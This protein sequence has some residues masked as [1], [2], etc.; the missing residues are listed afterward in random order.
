MAQKFNIVAQLQLQGPGNVR[1]VVSRLQRQLGGLNANVNLNVSKSGLQALQN[2]QKSLNNI[3]AQVAK[4]NKTLSQLNS[5]TSKTSS[6]VNKTSSSLKEAGTSAQNFGHQI[7]LATKRFAAFSI[8]GGVLISFTSALKTGVSEAINFE[9]QMVKV[10]QVTGKT[11]QSL[12][13]L[14]K[15]I[16]RLA[17]GMGV[18]SSELIDV[19]RTLAQTGLAAKD[20]T[21]ALKTLAQSSLAPTF[22]DMANTAEGAIAIMRQ[23]GVTA[24]QLGGKLGSINALAGQFAVESQDLIFAIRRAGG[25]FQAAGGNLEE[26]LALFTSVRATTRES[27]ETIATGF[28]TIFTRIQRPKTIEFLRQAGVELQN[29]QGNFVGPFEAIKRLNKALSTLET[30]DPRFQQIIEELGGFRQVSK[31]IPLIQQFGTAQRALNVAIAGQGSLAKDAVTAQQSLAVQAV[32]VREQFLALFREIAGTTAFQAFAKTALSIASAMIKVGDAIKPVLPLI[33]GLAAFKT[34]QLGSQFVSG[35]AGGLGGGGARGAGRGAAGQLTGQAQ[36]ASAA[37]QVQALTTNTTAITKLTAAVNS[38]IPPINRLSSSNQKIISSGAMGGRSG[39]RRFA[40]GGIVPGT[41]TG[42]TVPAMLEPGE[43]VIRKSSVEKYGA[44]NLQR[45]NRGGKKRRGISKSKRAYAFDFDDTLA[46]SDAVVREGAED[47]YVDFRGKRGESFVKSATATKIASMA[48]TRASRGHDIFV[49][50]ARPGDSSTRRGISGFMS[51][52]G[53]TAKDIIGVGGSP[54]PGDTSQKKAQVLN[55]LKKQYGNIT[56]LDDDDANVLA[57]SKIPG[58]KSI[59]ARK[60]M[61]GKISSGRGLPDGHALLYGQTRKS[62]PLTVAQKRANDRAAMKRGKKKAD[63]DELPLRGFPGGLPINMTPRTHIGGIHLRDGAKTKGGA[64]TAI[65]YPGIKSFDITNPAFIDYWKRSTAKKHKL[66]SRQR[67]ATRLQGSMNKQTFMSYAPSPG[68]LKEVMGTQIDRAAAKGA[69]SGVGRAVS[70]LKKNATFKKA[71]VSVDDNNIAAAKA[72][73][74]SDPNVISSV[75]GFIY[76][77]VLTALTGTAMG[78][79]KA[80]FDIPE[81]T[82]NQRSAWGKLFGPGA[83]KLKT[84]EV[85]RSLQEMKAGLKGTKVTREFNNQKRTKWRD[86]ANVNKDSIQNRLK[87]ARRASGGGISGSDTVPAL[88]TPGEFVVN[89]KSA[90]RIGYGALDKI[91]KGQAQGFA[92]GGIVKKFRRGGRASG[93]DSGRGFEKL[94]AAA[95]VLPNILEQLAA[96]VGTTN[97]TFSN[98]VSGLTGFLGTLLTV[99]I[100]FES[101]G[102]QKLL[103]GLPGAAGGKRF[104]RA[105]FGRTFSA[106]S[107]R[108]VNTLGMGKVRGNVKAFGAALTRTSAGALAVVSAL[109]SAGVAIRSFGEKLKKEAVESA[110][111]AKNTADENAAQAKFTKGKVISATGT[112]MAGGAVAGA[113]IGSFIP[114]IGTLLGGLIG[115]VVGAIGGLVAGIFGSN[116]EVVDAINRGRQARH[117]ESIDKNM[118]KL[119]R[120]GATSSVVGSIV[121]DVNRAMDNM[122][123]A[124]DLEQMEK[125]EQEMKRLVPELQKMTGE[126]AKGSES[127]SDF[128]SMMGGKGRE[129]IEILSRLTG[130]PYEELRGEYKR[131]IDVARRLREAQAAAAEAFAAQRDFISEIN[132][133]RD[134]ILRAADITSEFADRVSGIV[135]AA[136]GGDISATFGGTRQSGN[137]LGR[138]AEGER[139]DP[140]MLSQ[141]IRQASSDENVRQQAAQQA[142]LAQELPGVLF[143]AAKAVGPGMDSDIKLVDA[144]KKSLQSKGFTG[145]IANSVVT[146]VGTMTTG[147]QKGEGTARDEIIG[148]SRAV[149]EKIRGDVGPQVLQA[150]QEI[151]DAIVQSQENLLSMLQKRNDLEEAYT[152]ARQRLLQKQNQLDDAE[153]Q[154]GRDVAGNAVAARTD[155]E[156]RQEAARRFEEEQRAIIGTDFLG[157]GANLNNPMDPQELGDLIQANE[158]Q[159][160]AQ[161]EYIKEL[162]VGS[163]AHLAATNSLNTLGQEGQRL[164]AGLSNLAE[165]TTTLSVLQKQ[166]GEEQKRREYTQSKL[167][168][169][170]F[171]TKEQRQNF[172]TGMRGANLLQRGMLP[173]EIARLGPQGEQMMQGGLAQLREFA[174]A[175]IKVRDFEKEA[176]QG[177]GKKIMVDADEIIKRQT[178]KQIKAELRAAPPNSAAAKLTDKQID[179][180][181]EKRMEKGKGEKELEKKILEAMNVQRQAAEKIKEVFEKTIETTDVEVKNAIVE[182]TRSIR[183]AIVAQAQ[184]RVQ[185]EKETAQ[186]E[187]VRAQDKITTRGQLASMGIGGRKEAEAV[188]GAASSFDEIRRSAK[189]LHRLDRITSAGFGGAEAKKI[190]SRSHGVGSDVPGLSNS[191]RAEMDAAIN[192]PMR[193]ALSQI[194]Q[195]INASNI[196]VEDNIAGRDERA[197]ISQRVFKQVGEQ[198]N[199]D[200]SPEELSKLAVAI[201]SLTDFDADYFDTDFGDVSDMIGKMAPAFESIFSGAKDAAG[202][203]ILDERQRLDEANIDRG[204]QNSIIR[205]DI[206]ISDIE[207]K[208]RSLNEGLKKT[209][210]WDVFESRLDSVNAKLKGLT[211]REGRLETQKQNVQTQKIPTTSTPDKP[212]PIPPVDLAS[213]N[214]YNGIPGAGIRLGGATSSTAISPGIDA[215]FQVA[216]PQESTQAIGV[217]ERTASGVE[218]LVAVFESKQQADGGDGSSISSLT[219]ALSNFSSSEKITA[220]TDSLNNFTT[221]FG[222]GIQMQIS[223]LDAVQVNVTG[224]DSLEGPVKSATIEEIQRELTRIAEKVDTPA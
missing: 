144:V 181:V 166:L 14:E 70:K 161:R 145:T 82:K 202:T 101:L 69:S 201:N 32:K 211:D 59:K 146:A 46:V 87:V 58:V 36:A 134:A 204:L 164:R 73:T 9:R 127:I 178:K 138:A 102:A 35:F 90:Q 78:G 212:N 64:D 171:G 65:R 158:A 7:A 125:M 3:S 196:A 8:G 140:A 79:D 167:T 121:N 67:A 26:L 151:G 219:N 214:I 89:K 195:E 11:L 68:D 48:K 165:S 224:L 205:G 30:T 133:F 13:F 38:L 40:T 162:E 47:P 139:V 72:A 104:S 156:A 53:V 43:F 216:A 98:L 93:G 10:A 88:L 185:A 34:F 194:F 16:S 149:A 143:D 85:K 5:T 103:E 66:S 193:R 206:D 207:Q 112:G 179:V 80:A 25:A 218:R 215:P 191:T 142:R 91:N 124:G 22:K 173:Q 182:G 96:S 208:A 189:E 209:D 172:A 100:A 155:Q 24:D 221:S 130:V 92:S 99:K 21:T 184:E 94:T 51:K 183:E 50:T 153:Q 175:G 180:L 23:F 42:D 1:Q 223:G 17:S 129:A 157:Y 95:I 117:L 97:K 169:I 39:R 109:A 74:E 170:A 110:E 2:M 116:K 105:S 168:D 186:K 45:L 83:E 148:D 126:M 41:G 111:R 75:A 188:V 61:G 62:K 198:E 56:F 54:G 128:E 177:D 31:V 150:L 49:V 160:A 174:G 76:E 192:S 213:T 63:A 15:E 107:N 176:E 60:A 86:I 197:R 18:A 154:F 122:A 199:L 136:L 141:A 77:G 118:K 222:D 52:I 123:S 4:T 81:I 163:S 108:N 131:Q 12:G 71:G 114:V 6:N 113:A 115:S 190:R 203:R 135:N 44:E 119:E 132:S 27:A 217:A 187:Q 152:Q 33:A 120:Q 84:G 55:R 28:R 57:A 200:F 106:L 210:G 147:R 19:S 137:I 159:I 29:L 37:K 220:L 20:V